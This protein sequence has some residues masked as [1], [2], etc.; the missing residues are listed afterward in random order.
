MIRVG[1][2]PTYNALEEH[3]LFIRTP[4]Q[5]RARNLILQGAV[6]YLLNIYT[7]AFTI[8][9]YTTIINKVCDHGRI[10]TRNSFETRSVFWGGHA[11]T[12]YVANKCTP[13]GTR[14]RN[15]GFVDHSDIQFHHRGNCQADA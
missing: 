13:A 12:L 2:K 11:V 9:L 14:I 10:P 3:F 15:D 6:S 7:Y 5:M 1:F 4:D 8:V